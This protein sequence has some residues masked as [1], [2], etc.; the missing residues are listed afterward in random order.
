LSWGAAGGD[1]PDKGQDLLHLQLTLNTVGGYE[2]RAVQLIR[3]LRNP[4]DATLIDNRMYILEFG[5][6]VALWEVEF[7]P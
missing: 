1:L 7:L 4:I 5:A 6:D 3:D 2:M